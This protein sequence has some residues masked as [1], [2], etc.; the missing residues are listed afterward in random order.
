MN[1]IKRLPDKVSNKIAAGEVIERPASVVKELVENSIDADSKTIDIRINEGGKELIQVIDDGFGMTM[2]DAEIALKRFSTSKIFSF[3][4]LEHLATFGFRG[5]A[6]SSIASVSLLELKTKTKSEEEGTYLRS[7]GGENCNIK[8]IPWNRGT[9]ISIKN[10]F[11]NT[12]VR[13]KFQKNALS[14]ARRIYRMFRYFALAYPELSFQLSHDNR[15]IWKLA[16]AGLLERM[17]DLFDSGI[18]QHLL[19]L[20]HS[21]EHFSVSGFISV[22]EWTRST[23]ND[24]YL[25]LNKR[26]IKNKIIEHAVVQGYGQSLSHSG[27]FPFYVIMLETSPDRFDINI[28]P[29]KLEA[30]FQ[31]ER[32]LHHFISTAVKKALGVPKFE[33]ARIDNGGS[34][35]RSKSPVQEIHPV[36]SEV[37]QFKYE[38]P[39]NGSVPELKQNQI[40]SPDESDKPMGKN[41][42][43][44]EKIWQVH[45]C[46]IFSQVKNG[47]I[48][49]D[50]HTAHERI[51]YEKA[52]RMLNKGEKPSQQ[53]LFP[54]TI[55]LDK[56]DIIILSE[57]LPHLEKLGFDIRIFGIDTAVIEAVPL[58]IRIGRE[59]EILK[60]ILEEYRKDEYKD[61]DVHDRLARSFACRSAIMKGD[62]LSKGEMFNLID[63][64][65]ATEFPYY[66]PH[67][68]PTIIDM[69]LNDLNSKFLR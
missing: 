20:S 19:E 47:L 8:K 17:G 22:P 69:S 23:R 25:F 52:L 14:E 15:R 4:D 12:P 53:L 43:D 58:E 56:E 3:E 26:Y 13:R 10:I 11:F 41:Q 35:F 32:G 38:K 29:T 39:E 60:N 67:G 34:V 7:E 63:D 64:L 62:K 44:P 18:N 27:G 45:K 49:I 48:I 30:K 55:T 57:I 50:Q 2:Q 5:E 1:S 40:T 65:F 61:L 24:Q 51:L 9:S 37:I 59:I 33:P 66:C 21:D 28:H 42:I 36:N 54:Q 68:R 6:L 16:P 46:Y 31:D